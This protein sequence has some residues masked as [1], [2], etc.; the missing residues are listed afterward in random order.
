M[1]RPSDL[2]RK[3]APGRWRSAPLATLFRRGFLALALLGSAQ[4][5]AQADLR[6]PDRAPV[7]LEIFQ[8]NEDRLF[9]VGYRLAT[10]NAPFCDGAVSVSGLLVHDAYSYGNPEAVRLL[11]RLSGDIGVQSVAE[12]SPAARAGIRQNDTILSVDGRSIA[13][14]WPRSEPRWKRV[15]AIRDAIDAALAKGSVAI[16]WQSPGGEPQ[17]AVLEGVSACPTRFELI[18]SRKNAA[19]DGERVLVGENFPGFGYDEPVFAAVIGHEMAHNVFRHPQ[20]FNEI[21]WKRS[22]V[23]VSERDADRLMPWLLQNAGYDP[24]AAVTFMQTWGPRHGGG[25]LRKRTHD[26]WDERVEFI[27]AEI[28]ALRRVLGED[29]SVD[30][31]TH[32]AEMLEPALTARSERRAAR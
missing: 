23:R 30:W 8:Q 4:A 28:A 1:L 25:I 19:A 2:F 9:R 14:E 10:S 3:G 31:R 16:G 15:F 6:D 12:G 32:F 11:F 20:T 22:L 29:G 13:R 18:D 5:H 21:G 17:E 24:Q 27:E 7:P 26:G